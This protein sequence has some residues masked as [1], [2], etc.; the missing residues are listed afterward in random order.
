M[1]PRARRVRRLRR[2]DRQRRERILRSRWNPSLPSVYCTGRCDDEIFNNGTVVFLTHTARSGFLEVWCERIRKLSGQR[3]DWSMSGG[4]AVFKAL[5]DLDR[6]RKAIRSLRNEHD[7]AYYY[8]ARR[9]GDR[10]ERLTSSDRKQ[11]RRELDGIWA[12]NAKTYGR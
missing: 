6:V 8:A 4:R 10:V 3:V 2:E 1:N 9:Y 5:G 12:Y 7:M 11:R